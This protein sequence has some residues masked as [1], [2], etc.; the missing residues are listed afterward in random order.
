MPLTAPGLTVATYRNV[1]ALL[2]PV[3]R[4]WEAWAAAAAPDAAKPLLPAR[5]RSHWI[6]R[7]LEV[8]KQSGKVNATAPIHAETPA[9]NRKTATIPWQAVIDGSLPPGETTLQTARDAAFYGA[10]YVLEGS[11]LGGRFIA[12]HVEEVLGLHPGQGDLY[13]RGHGDQTGAL[14]R[15]TT[16]LIA[17]LPE[18]YEGIVIEAAKRTFKA[19]SS[20][21]TQSQ[22]A[23][24]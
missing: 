17:D 18:C 12:R 21:L 9:I 19:F 11:T 24:D 6:E 1:L 13:F 14:W 10:L 22:P 20:V 2:L 16:A 8:L 23:S 4:S 7:D 3:L 15:E 5:R